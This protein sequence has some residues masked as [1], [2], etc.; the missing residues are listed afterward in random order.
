MSRSPLKTQ[1]FGEQWPNPDYSKEIENCNCLHMAS[2]KLTE[3]NSEAC[4]GRSLPWRTPNLLLVF[5][6]VI[7][8]TSKITV[9]AEILILASMEEDDEEEEIPDEDPPDESREF[10]IDQFICR[11]CR[12]QL[13][14]LR[15]E[16]ETEAEI[17]AIQRRVNEK[18]IALI[19]SE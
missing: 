8:K 2:P 9:I 15:G 14:K 18:G 17:T 5:S 3:N 13:Q 7:T 1:P 16:A 4:S 6:S 10:H 11:R 19:G 12:D